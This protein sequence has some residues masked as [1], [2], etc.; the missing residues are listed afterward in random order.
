MIE[1]D[2]APGTMV[3]NSEKEVNETSSLV[4]LLAK[5]GAVAMF[6]FG[7]PVFFDNGNRAMFELD[8]H[9][10]PWSGSGA[11]VIA[12]KQNNV[13]VKEH[14]IVTWISK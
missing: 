1:V 14:Y 10:G 4:D 13:W 7:R 8:H 5:Y 3:G 11:M 9:C 6:E 2:D 12:K